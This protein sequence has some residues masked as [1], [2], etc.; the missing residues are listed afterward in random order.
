MP[1]H[2]LKKDS[3]GKRVPF[4][5]VSVITRLEV[6]KP[7]EDIEEVTEE[8]AKRIDDEEETKGCD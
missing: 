7:I 1:V 3:L 2:K 5:W 6:R 8:D 4:N